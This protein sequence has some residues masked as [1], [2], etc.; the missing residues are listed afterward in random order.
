MILLIYGTRLKIRGGQI[1]GD[2]NNGLTFYTGN[3]NDNS[4]LILYSN[5]DAF[6]RGNVTI[7]STGIADTTLTINADY[8]RT[9]SL[10]LYGETSHGTGRVYVGQDI[11]YG[12]GFIYSG[13]STPTTIYSNDTITFFRRLVFWIVCTM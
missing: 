6:L 7:E 1:Y 4:S 11:N 9:A 8:R 3:Q 10:N 2:G 13:D 5:R 12:G